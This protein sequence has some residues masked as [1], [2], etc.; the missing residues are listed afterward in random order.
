MPLEHKYRHDCAFRCTLE[1]G[2]AS[3][4]GFYP[5]ELNQNDTFS[6]WEYL[7]EVYEHRPGKG[8]LLDLIQE[9]HR[10]VGL[11]Q[12]PK[13]QQ[14]LEEDKPVHEAEIDADRDVLAVGKRKCSVASVVLRKGTGQIIINNKS[15]QEYFPNM[16]GRCYVLSPFLATDTLGQFDATVTVGGGGWSGQSQAVRHGIARALKTYSTE[17]QESLKESGLLKRDP[18]IVER[19]KPGR[20]KARK[21]FQ[22]VKR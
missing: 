21:S 8:E 20:A 4:E 10:S 12:L 16:D 1:K 14:P 19:K 13:T 18:R 2:G 6:L 17:Y 5:K 15:L 11:R 7:S 3:D 9:V 22:W